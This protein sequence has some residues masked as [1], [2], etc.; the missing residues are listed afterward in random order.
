MPVIDKHAP[1]SF[2]WTELATPDQ[3]AAKA[4]YEGLFGWTAQDRP[5]GPAA[6]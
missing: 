6:F 1:G 2:C 3:Q 4:F 5:I